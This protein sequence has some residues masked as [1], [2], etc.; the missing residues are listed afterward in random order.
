MASKR[1]I[2]ATAPDG[3]RVESDG[4]GPKR[5]VGAIRIMD[6]RSW[7]AEHVAKW[8]PWLVTVHRTLDLAITGPN[9]TPAWNHHTRWAIAIGDD[10]Q[11][12]GDWV[13]ASK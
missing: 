2:T 10:D 6:T 7:G 11:P 1:R 3:A 13:P 12:T 4:L 5:V 9:Q 8:G